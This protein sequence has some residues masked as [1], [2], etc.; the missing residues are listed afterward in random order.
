[1]LEIHNCRPIIPTVDERQIT[2]PANDGSSDYGTIPDRGALEFTFNMVLVNSADLPWTPHGVD[3]L[4]VYKD[5]VRVINATHD[6]GESHLKY[7]VNGQTVTFSETIIGDMK[8]IC[9]NRM[10]PD[11]PTEYIIE[12]DN[13]FGGE[14]AANDDGIIV[15]DETWAGTWCEPVVCTQPYSGYVRL[16]DD[17]KS[18]IYVPNENFVGADAFSYT[19]ITQRGQIGD[20]KCVYITVEAPP[21][22]EPEPPE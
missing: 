21:P 19:I 4:E 13:I 18:M 9:D 10:A 14:E 15:T 6:F 1:M 8:F 12:I 5:G 7:E 2:V 3:I 17:R 20:P 16:T 11:V 22:P